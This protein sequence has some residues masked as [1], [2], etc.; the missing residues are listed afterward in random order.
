MHRLLVADAERE[1]TMRRMAIRNGTVCTRHGTDLGAKYSP[2][3]TISY[4]VLQGTSRRATAAITSP[5][6]W[7]WNACLRV[8]EKNYKTTGVALRRLV[9]CHGGDRGSGADRGVA[10]LVREPVLERA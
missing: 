8:T 2:P 5:M 1:C 9:P 6:P 7:V 10:A 4:R 3:R